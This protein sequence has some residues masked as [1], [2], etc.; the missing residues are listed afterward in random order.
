MAVAVIYCLSQA[1]STFSVALSQTALF[2]PDLSSYMK[3]HAGT[4]V[5]W[6]QQ[7]LHD[8]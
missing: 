1:Q 2:G 4:K 6:E 5:F 8:V 3:S 7:S